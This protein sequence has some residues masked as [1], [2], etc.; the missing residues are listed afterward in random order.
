MSAFLAVSRSLSEMKP[1]VLGPG[2]KFRNV[3][4]GG[5]FELN[6]VGAINSKTL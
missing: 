5:G 2:W 4:G 3:L 6:L 1:G